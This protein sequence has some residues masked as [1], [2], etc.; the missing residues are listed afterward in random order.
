MKFIVHEPHEF[1]RNP[2]DKTK[3]PSDKEFIYYNFEKYHESKS[4]NSKLSYP[5]TKH[6]TGFMVVS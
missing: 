4:D 3:Y 1:K 5:D 2:I 6:A